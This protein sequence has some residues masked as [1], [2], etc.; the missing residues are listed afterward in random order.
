[1]T[2]KYLHR[3]QT[4]RY[5]ML[6]GAMFVVCMFLCLCA[7]QTVV[8]YFRLGMACLQQRVINLYHLQPLGN[9]PPQRDRIWSKIWLRRRRRWYC[10]NT[11]KCNT[12]VL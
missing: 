3:A 4:V 11:A 2:V 10:G 6:Y 12:S 1:V 8:S 5:G 9:G 7:R